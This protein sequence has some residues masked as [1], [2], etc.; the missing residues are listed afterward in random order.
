V[1]IRDHAISL[2]DRRDWVYLLS[3]LVPLF[4]YDLALKVV[5]LA[6]GHSGV[7]VWDALGLLRSELL[8]D[9]GYVLVWIGLFAVARRGIARSLVLVLLH[10]SAILVVAVATVAF[11]YFRSTGTVLD[12]GVVAYYL[13]DPGEARGAVSSDAPMGAWLLLSAALLYVLPGPLLLTRALLP[14]GGPGDDSTQRSTHDEGRDA[15]RRGRTPRR[16]LTRQEFLAAGVGA[17]GAILLGESL[18]PEEAGAE[19]AFARDPVSNLVATELEQS[20]VEEAAKDARARHPLANARLTPTPRTERRHVA[21]IH[22]ESTRERSVTPYAPEIGTTP[23]LGALAKDS[24]LVERAYSTITHTSNAITSVN[25]GLYPSPDTDIVEAEPG[26]IPDRCLAELLGEQGYKS[27]WFQSAEKTFENRPQLVQNFGYGHFQAY[28]SMN[29]RGF[30]RA[31][32]LGYEDDVML[33][34][35]R[36]WLEENAS[37]PTLVTYLGVTPHD[38]YL[39]ID[40]YGRKRFS[41]RAMLDRYL[42]NIYYDDFW[43]ENIIEQYKRLGLYEGTIFV[44]YGD[45]GEAFGEHGVYHHDGAIWEEGLRVP[46]IVHDPKRFDGGERVPGPA[47]HL[48]IAPTVID[49]LGYEVVNGKYPG[50]TLLGLSEERTLFFGCRPDLLSAARIQGHKKYIYHFGNQQEEY[51]DL[52]KDPLEKNNLI[53][54]VGRRELERLRSEVLAWHAEAAAAYP[55]PGRS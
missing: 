43:V 48:D 21:L 50:S 1:R 39:P 34:S 22:L 30:Q 16:A 45:H 25:S 47:H 51:Y 41:S 27:A 49:M 29:R 8:F 53:S 9:S 14:I 55:Q 19:A 54:K 40:R 13:A 20:R 10:A 24:L 15:L 5:G 36:A 2:L 3:L 12:Y 37:S 17:A 44:I 32:Y 52:K 7:G 4:A 28:E 23:Y 6:S 31:N 11:Q 46:L 35:S 26:G 33:D 18:S 42:N 38:D